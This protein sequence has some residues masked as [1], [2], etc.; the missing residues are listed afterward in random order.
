MLKEFNDNH[1]DQGTKGIKLKHYFFKITRNEHL[2]SPEGSM[3]RF[4]DRCDPLI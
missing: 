3:K 4:S 1:R 2:S